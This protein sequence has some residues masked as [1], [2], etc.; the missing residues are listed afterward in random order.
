MSKFN[1]VINA[2]DQLR[3]ILE[4]PSELITRKT[5]KYLNKHSGV[6]R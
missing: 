5:L 2:R 1:N 6:S 4:E 3:C